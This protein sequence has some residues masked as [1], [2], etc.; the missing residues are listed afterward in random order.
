MIAFIL[1]GY[2]EE[3]TF[4]SNAIP[5]S[6]DKWDEKLT[7]SRYEELEINNEKLCE[8]NKKDHCQINSETS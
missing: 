1:G 2:E 8:G 7:C 4:W 6:S 5:L 3:T